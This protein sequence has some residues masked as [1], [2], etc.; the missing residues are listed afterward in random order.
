MKKKILIDIFYL[1]IAQ[2]GIK[3]YSESLLEAISQREVR[4]E[5]E[6]IISPN[7]ASI[8]TS[9]FFKGKT[10]KWKNLLF[11]LFYFIRKAIVLPILTYWYKSDIVLSPDILSPLW[12]RGRKVS[13]LHDAFFWENP[14]HYNSLWRKY[15][16]NALAFSL[17][18]NASVVTI[19]NYSRKQI[20]KYL[21][22]P[23]LS[24]EVV[25]PAT[26]LLAVPTVTTRKMLSKPYFLHV[27]VME[28]RKNLLT[29]IK[30]FKQ[31]LEGQN[32]NFYLVLVGQRGPRKDMDDYDAIIAEI[33]SSNLEDKV[34]LPGYVSREELDSYY[35]HAFGYIFPSLNEG[36]GMPVLE[37]FSYQ[38]PVIISRQGAL[39]EVGDEAVL[40]PKTNK[41]A[42]FAFEMKKI[43]SDP[44]L[45]GELVKKGN[46]RLKYFG[47][48]K[49]FLKDLEIYFEKL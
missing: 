33:K 45:R 10:P 35:R 12:A 11:Q 29:L 42:D 18:R 44:V 6:Y 3:T 13:V 15:F 22:L 40:C 48:G 43:E 47:D 5:Y 38:L 26:N 28:K 16:L 25:Y 24:I 17:R 4:E 49:R 41:A 1:H 8:K 2:T 37:A 31:F 7:H 14:S 36:F 9:T 19:T 21:N 23:K 20:E 32:S 46:N 30:A 27:G 34:I 39:M